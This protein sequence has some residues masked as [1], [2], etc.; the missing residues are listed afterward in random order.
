MKG[1]ILL[2]GKPVD[3]PGPD[4]GMIF[5][6]REVVGPRLDRAVVFQSPALLPWLTG[7]DNVQLSVTARDPFLINRN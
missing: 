7:R 5:D 3:G 4:R 1:Q 6:G 2:E